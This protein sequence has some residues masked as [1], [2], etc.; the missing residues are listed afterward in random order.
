MK[1]CRPQI[2]C[3]CHAYRKCKNLTCMRTFNEI[4]DI[5]HLEV[6]YLFAVT[7]PFSLYSV[8]G[9][10]PRALCCTNLIKVNIFINLQLVIQAHWC[11][12]TC[13]TPQS[14]CVLPVTLENPGLSVAYR[15]SSEPAL[16][17]IQNQNGKNGRKGYLN[18]SGCR[19]LFL[20][21]FLENK[22]E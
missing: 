5:K 11:P 13:Q 18:S 9:I 1:I 16:N 22:E 3:G 7:R 19:I 10:I 8:S 20:N 6:C 4:R 17:I 2:I 14:T 21:P 12:Q 15:I